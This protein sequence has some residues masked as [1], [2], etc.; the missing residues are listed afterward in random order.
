MRELSTDETNAVGGGSDV[1]AVWVS[2]SPDLKTG[3]PSLVPTPWR[4]TRSSV[5]ALPESE[6]RKLP[7]VPVT[8]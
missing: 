5:G 1:Q 4:H 7:I 6:Y 8:I 2:L 3:E